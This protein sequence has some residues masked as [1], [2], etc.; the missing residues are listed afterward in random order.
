MLSILTQQAI[1]TKFSK[2]IVEEPNWMLYG[3]IKSRL[4]QQLGIGG[5]YFIINTKI[6][7]NDYIESL[8]Q[9]TINM[10]DLY[11]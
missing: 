3:R 11:N 8:F 5:A 6:L 10:D 7:I 2:Q 1:D 9:E 4:F